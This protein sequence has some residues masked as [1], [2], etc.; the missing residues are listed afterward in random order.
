MLEMT[1]LVLLWG[2]ILSVGGS[3]LIL[4]LFLLAHCAFNKNDAFLFDK[5]CL[6]VGSEKK[7]MVLLHMKKNPQNL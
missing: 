4:K 3:A 7:G 2:P 1:S 5:W 6:K